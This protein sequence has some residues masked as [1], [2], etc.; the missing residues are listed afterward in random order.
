MDVCSFALN[1]G[2]DVI[3]VPCVR[4]FTPANAAL[5]VC[6]SPQRGPEFFA[7][8]SPVHTTLQTR[9]GRLLADG[10]VSPVVS[11]SPARRNS[12]SRLLT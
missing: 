8:Q 2:H 4:Q 12:P 10:L 1:P 6:H 9:S 3:G 11:T 5:A 7:S